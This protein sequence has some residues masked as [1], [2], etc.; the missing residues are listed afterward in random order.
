MTDPVGNPFTS[1]GL[2]FRPWCLEDTS[3]MVSLFDTDQMNRW[4]PLAS[5]FTVQAAQGYVAQ[6]LDAGL[7]AG[8]LQFAVLL[9]PNGPPVGEVLVF[10]SD[11]P[12]VMELAYAVGARYQRQGIA[13]RALRAALEVARAR[14]AR[15]AVLSIAEGNDASAGVA[16]AAGFSLTDAPLRERRRKGFVLHMSTWSRDL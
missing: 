13:S 8:I 1:D 10:P 16:V 3:E 2:W 7:K 12:G 9:S 11:Q 5:P 15:Q 6:A 4:T 14:G